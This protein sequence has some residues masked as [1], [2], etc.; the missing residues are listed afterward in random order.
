MT[1]WS[2]GGRNGPAPAFR[3]VAYGCALIEPPGNKI[4]VLQTHMNQ[5]FSIH[6]VILKSCGN[7]QWTP[8]CGIKTKI[9]V[10]AYP[11]TQIMIDPS[12]TQC[13]VLRVGTRMKKLVMSLWRRNEERLRLKRC[14]Y[15]RSDFMGIREPLVGFYPVAKNHHMGSGSGQAKISTGG[16]YPRA[17]D[18]ILH[19]IARGSHEVILRRYKIHWW[20]LSARVNHDKT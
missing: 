16:V 5:N 18:S 6:R 20:I 2:R 7:G 12:R 4:S 9:G 14:R 10:G 3:Y 17:I 13:C 8:D 15:A 11:V 1:V 19:R